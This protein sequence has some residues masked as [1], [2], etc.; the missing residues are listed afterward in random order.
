MK[1]LGGE[2]LDE[3]SKKYVTAIYMFLRGD[4]R[5]ACPSVRAVRAHTFKGFVM[6]LLRDW[7]PSSYIEKLPTPAELKELYPTIYATA[8]PGESN[9]SPRSMED[10]NEIEY[11]DGLMQCRVGSA[12]RYDEF[13][14]SAM[15]DRGFMVPSSSFRD[16]QLSAAEAI[17]LAMARFMQCSPR[18]SDHTPIQILTQ[19]ESV[20]PKG[21]PMRSLSNIQLDPH[22]LAPHGGAPSAL[23]AAPSA[24]LSG[25]SVT[26][27]STSVSSSRVLSSA[28]LEGQTVLALTDG[29]ETKANMPD[30]D[31]PEDNLTRVAKR[32]RDR[33]LCVAEEVSEQ[34][35]SEPDDGEK[36]LKRPAAQKAAE[37]KVHK[38]GAKAGTTAGDKGKTPNAVVKTTWPR[39]PTIGWETSRSQVMRRTGR[40]GPGSSYKITFAKAG[41]AKKAWRAAQDWLSNVMK[42]HEAFHKG[43]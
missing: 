12:R 5:S 18:Q 16:P 14:S 13:A 33:K 36:V 22:A 31:K 6:K 7:E 9:P 25:V 37:K 35:S 40:G 11:L 26:A 2:N 43:V 1:T 29:F 24:A 20:Q 34:N 38:S 39:R 41:S 17:S 21:R 42:K 27:P 10:L 3:H 15:L 30:H 28:P 19:R 32:M 4:A 23:L 8:F